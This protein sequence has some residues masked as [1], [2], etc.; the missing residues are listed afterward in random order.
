MNSGAQWYKKK[1]QKKSASEYTIQ[2]SNKHLM[3]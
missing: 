2:L 3:H 1:Q